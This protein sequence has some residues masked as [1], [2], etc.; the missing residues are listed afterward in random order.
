MLLVLKA[1]NLYFLP[2]RV[3]LV[4]LL[5]SVISIISYCYLRNLK[6]SLALA[7]LVVVLL[8]LL[9]GH[10]Q[11]KVNIPV[12][13]AGGDADGESIWIFRRTF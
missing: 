8:W 9:L 11:G 4:L 6:L 2:L 5:F 10:H 7:S 1:F 3:K 12:C 13:Y